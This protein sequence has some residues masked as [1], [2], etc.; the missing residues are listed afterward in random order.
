MAVPISYSYRNLWARRLTTFLT[1]MGISLVVF[2]FAAILMLNAG[3]KKTLVSTGSDDNYVVIR[4]SANSDILSMVSRES[5]SLVETFPEVALTQEGKPLNSREVAIIINLSKYES[6]D[7]GNVIVRGVSP[8]AIQ[9]RPQIRIIQGRPFD[10]GKSEVI[11]GKSISE[12]FKGCRLG[13][14]LKFGSR[15]WTIV[16]IFEAQKSG[17]ESEI[18]GDVEQ[19]VSA[20]KRPVYSTLTVRLRDKNDLS[21]FQTRFESEPRLQQLQVKNEKVYFSE[22]SKALGQFISVLGLVITSIFSFG[23]MI[24]AMITMYASVANR[25]SEIGTLRA[26]GYQRRSILL[27]FLIEALLLSLVGGA[28]GIL[29]ASLL[30]TVTISMLNFATFSELAFGF[31]MTAGIVVASFIFAAVMGVVGGFLPAV[32]AARLGIVNALRAS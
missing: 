29:L 1:L 21:A 30:Q 4:K 32:R 27:S 25:T 5:A 8:Q 13:E 16:G 24:G 17:F 31:Q 28:L 10:P 23:A 22:Q 6:N 12:R 19:I 14:V 15:N 20:F 26:L 9:L 2:V 18:W 3:L 7:L 11:V